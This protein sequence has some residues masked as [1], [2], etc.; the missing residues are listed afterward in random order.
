MPRMTTGKRRE[1]SQ[2]AAAKAVRKR[3]ISRTMRSVLRYGAIVL[4]VAA[5]TGAGAWAWQSG[6]I[7]QGAAHLHALWLDST[8]G[9]GLNIQ[10]VLVDGRQ[11]TSGTDVLQ[12]LAVRRGDPI[13]A[14]DPGAA[15][16]R[17]EALAWVKSATVERRLP[18]SVYVHLEEHRPIARWQIDHRIR[19]IDDAGGVLTGIDPAPFVAL[20]LVV[21]PDAPQHA[22]P[23]LDSLAD[24]PAITDQ[25]R[26]AIR[27]GNRRWD[28]QLASGARVK[29]PEGDVVEALRLLA[30]QDAR[31]VLMNPDILSIDLRLGDRVFFELSP[32]ASQRRLLPEQET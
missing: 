1:A 17:L 19:L 2:R 7:A 11:S 4:A 6:R 8:A 15:R 26:A 5:V 9:A 12:A 16:T 3:P 28:L 27:V 14:L 18:D 24:V 22:M 20:P 30:E 23:L 25:L 13:L 21:G 29:L 31:I 32:M 10:E